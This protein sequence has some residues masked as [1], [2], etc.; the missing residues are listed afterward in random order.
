MNSLSNIKDGL[1]R[2]A[3]DEEV[4]QIKNCYNVNLT[5]SIMNYKKFIG[6]SYLEFVLCMLFI[7]ISVNIFESFP[8]AIIVVFAVIG[9]L[10]YIL[11]TM[12]FQGLG[13]I[14]K[15]LAVINKGNFKLI[16]GKVMEIIKHRDNSSI[17][18]IT[19]ESNEENYIEY[20]VIQDENTDVGNELKLVVFNVGNN[21]YTDCFSPQML[22]KK[23]L[24]LCTN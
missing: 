14:K 24:S 20:M 15:K 19:F 2:D 1:L 11:G 6:L 17:Y 3:T 22:S 5:R 16:D 12:S 13:F 9:V 23:D 4:S 7:L 10:F 18:S 8:L 21:Q